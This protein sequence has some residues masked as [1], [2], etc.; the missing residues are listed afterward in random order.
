MRLIIVRV[1]KK[2]AEVFTPHNPPVSY[3][4]ESIPEK[5]ALMECSERGIEGRLI[6]ASTPKIK[7]MENLHVFILQ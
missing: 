2:K 4:P 1:S 5:I 6:P 7:Q 3:P